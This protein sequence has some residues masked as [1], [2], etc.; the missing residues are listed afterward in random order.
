LPAATTGATAAATKAAAA[1]AVS[2]LGRQLPRATTMSFVFRMRCSVR[3]VVILSVWFPLL[4]AGLLW[5][6]C[7]RVPLRCMLPWRSGSFWLCVYVWFV[8]SLGARI[9]GWAGGIP[10]GLG[11]VPRAS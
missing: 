5:P 9:K 11:W 4:L 1:Q 6:T 2:L 3:K 8:S 7:L 10:G